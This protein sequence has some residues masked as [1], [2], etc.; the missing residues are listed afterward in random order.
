M[1]KLM[2]SGIGRAGLNRRKFFGMA[3]AG[4]AAL[5]TIPTIGIVGCST[6]WIGTAEKDAP[7]VVAIAETVVSIVASLTGNP[8]LTPAAIAIIQ[9]ASAAFSAAVKT[10]QDAI[11][12]YNA[13]KGTGTLNA[14]IAAMNA[15]EE[16]APAIIKAIVQAPGSIISI[17]TTAVGYALQLISAIQGLLPSTVL[18]GNKVAAVPSK[19]VAVV[20]VKLPSAQVIKSG[21]NSVLSVYGYGQFAVK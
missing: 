4:T 6:D 16:D 2:D 1:E 10:L 7:I 8:E 5:A 17:I 12:A 20:G 3:A 15:V 13:A 9:E 14:V 18:T 21:F 19:R 11:N